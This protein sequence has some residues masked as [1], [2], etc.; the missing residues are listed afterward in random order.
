[1][2]TASSLYAI[3][4]YESSHRHSTFGQR[5]KPVP[6]EWA[7]RVATSSL[8]PRLEKLC[9]ARQARSCSSL[10]GERTVGLFFWSRR[11]LENTIGTPKR[12]RSKKV[13]Q[14]L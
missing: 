5:G 6:V 7:V 1:M 11:A 3:S 2:I 8:A 9:G 4:A 13:W 14:P 10:T 12:P